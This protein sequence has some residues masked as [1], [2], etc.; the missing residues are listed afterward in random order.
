MSNIKL[1]VIAPVYNEEE[2]IGDFH[3]SLCKVLATLDDVDANILYVVD[4]C[5]D[6]TL[7]VLRSIVRREPR[8]KVIALS[9]RFGHQ[10]SL[11]AGIDNALDS[12]A[13]IM[14]DSDLQHPPELIPELIDNFRR[15]FEVVYTVRENTEAI[16]P[17]RKLAGALFYR[18]LT[19]V[20]QT[21][22][23]ANAADFRLISGRVAKVLSTD[24]RERNM[25]LRGLFSWMGFRQTG[26]AYVARK[27]GGGY[28]KYSLS[29]MLQLATAGILSF[30]TKPLQLGIFVGVMFSLL[31]FVMIIWAVVEFFVNKSIPSG[32][33][34]LVVLLLM[35]SGIQLIVLGIIGAYIGGIYE[36]VKDRPRYIIDEQ[37]TCY[38]RTQG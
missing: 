10:M 4:R 38:E 23:N 21:P 19:K 8:M 30:S 34:T 9:S 27:R 16:S 31:S 35:F 32:W 18:L 5:T 20:S 33:T 26:V 6:N 37:I 25:F 2:V 36:E 28:S 7:E 24:F 1:S 3:A 17:L 15:G 29:K 12:D 22:L 13:I 11:V 14:M